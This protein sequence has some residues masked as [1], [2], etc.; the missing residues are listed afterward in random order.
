M[1]WECVSCSHLR[2]VF[3]AH[4]R[5]PAVNR[6]ALNPIHGGIILQMPNKSSTR[7]RR[8]KDSALVVRI[9]VIDV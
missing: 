4:I 9:E 7:R 5:A 8:R 1:Y 2:D 6:T 3:F